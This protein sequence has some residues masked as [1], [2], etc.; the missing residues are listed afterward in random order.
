MSAF[1]ASRIF[2]TSKPHYELLDGLRGVAALMVIWY[3]F[4]EGFATSPVDQGF[5]HGYLAVD[6]FFVLSGFVIGYAYDGRW[7][8]G[9]TKGE[10]MLRRVIRLH[11]MLVMGVVFGVVAFMIQGSEQWDHTPVASWSVM[12]CFLLGILMLPAL[13]HTAAEVRGNG[14]MFPLN[15][16][17]WS[18]FFEYIASIAYAVVLHRLSGRALRWVVALS[19]IGLTLTA[20]MNLSGAYH[21]G[22]GWTAADYGWLGGLLRVSFSFSIGLLMSRGFKPVRIRGAFWI[23]SATIIGVMCVPYITPD[24]NPS[25]WNGIFDSVMTL[26]VFPAVVYLGASGCT[27]DRI[28]RG[29]CDFFGNISYPIYIIHYP[30]MYLLYAWIWAAPT[31]RAFADIWPLCVAMWFGLILLA[32]VLLKVYDE[33]VRRWLNRKAFGSR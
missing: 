21:I 16:P 26:A 28:S 12:L 10:F 8:Q 20:V 2:S 6:F 31:E 9:L 33:P 11:P 27:T 4:F 3:H 25:V 19:G 24:G 13:P 18:L 17:A 23:C 15:G 14:E 29:L 1:T 5:N 30:F 7:R 22:N 32:W